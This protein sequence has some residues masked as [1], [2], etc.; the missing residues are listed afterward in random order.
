MRF[1]LQSKPS[2][3]SGKIRIVHSLLAFL[4]L[5]RSWEGTVPLPHHELHCRGVTAPDFI[6]CT[7]YL[8]HLKVEHEFVSGMFLIIRMACVWGSGW[9]VKES[10]LRSD[11]FQHESQTLPKMQR[12]ATKGLWQTAPRLGRWRRWCWATHRCQVMPRDANCP[13]SASY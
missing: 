9:K 13:L 5:S 3:F 7:L 2:S 10:T 4:T 6:S 8:T 1:H 12:M 11:W